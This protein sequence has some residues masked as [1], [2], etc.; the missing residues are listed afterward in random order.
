MRQGEELTVL[1]GSP[2]RNPPWSRDE[3]I[4]ALDL[5]LRHRQSPPGKNSSEVIGLSNLLNKMGHALGLSERE[6]FRNPNGVY[7]KLMNFRSYD[8]EYTKDGK[9][10]LT[11]GNKDEKVVWNEFAS[12]PERLFLTASAIRSA[13][14]KPSDD[15]DL[16]GPEEPEI[17]EAEEGRVLTRLHRFRERDRKLVEAKKKEALKKHGRLSCEVCGFDFSS[18]YGPAGNGIIDIHHTT[19]VHTLVQGQKTRLEDLALLCANCHRM[20]HSSRKWLSLVEVIGFIM[21]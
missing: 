15:L 21:R 10:G 4:L 14:E 7:M 17:Q 16:S 8:P 19:P 13:I 9:V 5:Y 20:V 6:K 12:D 2:K 11:R 18:K 1:D 3:L